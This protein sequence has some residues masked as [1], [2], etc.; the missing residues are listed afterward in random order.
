MSDH[1]L[2]VLRHRG[3]E[4]AG[5][6]LGETGFKRNPAPQPSLLNY[7]KMPLWPAHAGNPPSAPALWDGLAH[8]GATIRMAIERRISGVDGRPLDGFTESP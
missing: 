1:G 6:A 7:S 8:A 2:F 4:N 5:T 3:G